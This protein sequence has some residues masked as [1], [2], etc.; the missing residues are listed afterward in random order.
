MSTTTPQSGDSTDAV[1]AVGLDPTDPRTD[2]ALT[3]QMTVR[4]CGRFAY[5]VYAESGN[6]Y[7]VHLGA[8]ACT[9]PDW[10]NRHPEDGCKHLRRVRL[11]RARLGVETGDE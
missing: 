8:E 5:E 10:Q 9:C 7:F 11:E 1:R 4:A 3:E 6:T 2:R